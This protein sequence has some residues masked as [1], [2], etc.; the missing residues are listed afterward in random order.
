MTTCVGW[1]SHAAWKYS[2]KTVSPFP[3]RM[4][5]AMTCGRNFSLEE[6][7]RTSVSKYFQDSKAGEG[8]RRSKSASVSSC[9]RVLPSFASP[10]SSSPP[11]SP[12][13]PS[14][15]TYCFLV[16]AHTFTD[17]M[18]TKVVSWSSGATL[19]CLITLSTSWMSAL[20]KSKTMSEQDS[21]SFKYCSWSTLE[22]T[23]LTPICCTI[24]VL[25]SVS[26]P[27]TVPRSLF[28]WARAPRRSEHRA[29]PTKPSTLL[30]KMRMVPAPR[31][32][33]EGGKYI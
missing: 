25:P 9:G 8:M 28:S 33:G 3:Y 31:S 2:L 13:S 29:L 5:A 21:T 1:V 20:C 18:S 27:V 19:R 15:G 7:D 26:S 16:R 17:E 11:A 23:R 22:T 14:N 32:N 6:S 24:S 10:S 4:P 30:M 12:S